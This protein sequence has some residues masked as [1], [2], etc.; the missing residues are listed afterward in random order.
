MCDFFRP[1][2]GARPP[3][4]AADGRLVRE[5]FL[6]TWRLVVRHYADDARIIGW[7][8]FNEPAGLCFGLDGAF[9]REA[10]HPLYRRMREITQEEHAART[11]F[12]EPHVI[13]NIGL[14]STLEPFGPDVV[15][16]PHLYGPTEVYDGNTTR[17]RAD[18]DTAIAEA[19][20]LGGPLVVGEVGGNV[21]GGDRVLH[22]TE[23]FLRDTY[24]ELDRH[25]SG[26]TMWAYF[27]QDN[28]FSVV[29]ANGVEKGH[30]VDM[31]ARPYARRIAGIPLAMRFDVETKEFT[32]SFRDDD[33]RQPLDPTEIFVPASRHYP[34][35]FT[36]EVSERDRWEL[37]ASGTRIMLF[38]GGDGE[39]HLRLRAK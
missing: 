15:Y 37:D 35:G 23:R 32:L 9:E 21:D 11:F 26:G 36:I 3:A 27:P 5:H 13:R 16:A 24:D 34:N 17:L 2:G 31:I 22:A 29:D 7:D 19:V 39:H 8:Y 6:D 1:E 18:Y 14:T 28:G 20:T 4:R 30:L 38:R 10:L 12:Y 33:A 25:L